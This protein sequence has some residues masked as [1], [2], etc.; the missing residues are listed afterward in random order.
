MLTIEDCE[1]VLVESLLADKELGPSVDNLLGRLL[2]DVSGYQ[3]H[4]TDVSFSS[5]RV[6]LLVTPL[7]AESWS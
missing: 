5:T 1:R 3:A 2:F 6:S 7:R 4:A